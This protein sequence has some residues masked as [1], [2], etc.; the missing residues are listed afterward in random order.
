MT[1][2]RQNAIIFWSSHGVEGDLMTEVLEYID[3]I[4]S[5]NSLYEV[6]DNWNSIVNDI[7]SQIGI[8]DQY[9]I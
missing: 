5:E 6:I 9:E 3:K 4:C 7:N 2:I 1:S 8:E